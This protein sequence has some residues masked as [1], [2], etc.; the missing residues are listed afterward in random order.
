MERR[1]EERFALLIMGVRFAFRTNDQFS[2]FIDTLFDYCEDRR[3]LYHLVVDNTMKH[4]LSSVV[5]G[6]ATDHQIIMLRAVK[7][8]RDKY[9]ETYDP[10]KE[11]FD[12][13]EDRH[14]ILE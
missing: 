13:L 6:E 10:D 3:E 14:N 2:R 8:I 12:L 1:E 7:T 9:G 11:A 5:D 4:V